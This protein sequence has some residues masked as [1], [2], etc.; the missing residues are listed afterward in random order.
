M[1]DMTKREKPVQGSFYQHF[2]GNL[3]QIKDIAIHSETGE[4][5]V[6]YQAMYPPF[7]TWARPLEMFLGEVD[8][9]KYPEVKQKHRF[10][11]VRFENVANGEKINA[12][13][14]VDKSTENTS[15]KTNGESG[16]S[17]ADTMNISEEEWKEIL[18]NNQVEKKL[19]DIFSKEEI[20]RKGLMIF[21]D[22]NTFQEKR[23]IF[24][25]LRQ[26]MDKRFLSNVAVSLDITLEEGSMEEQYDAVLYY[27]DK[28]TQYEGGRLR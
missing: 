6:V 1:I 10:E 22:A 20:A 27:I 4:E 14:E 7:G 21:L 5:M 28:R 18:I 26:C 19:A 13:A 17:L 3:Y 15:E 2:K 8:H 25:G 23:E 11:R 16:V 9:E 24:V 12:T